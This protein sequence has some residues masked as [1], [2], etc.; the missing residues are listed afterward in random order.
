MNVLVGEKAHFASGTH[1]GDVF[2]M[3][4]FTSEVQTSKQVFP[5]DALVALEQILKG[6]AIG[7]PVEHELHRDPC[8]LDHGLPHQHTGPPLNPISPTHREPSLRQLRQAYSE[9]MA[10]EP[11]ADLQLGCQF[12]ERL[13]PAASGAFGHLRV[14]PAGVLEGHL[15][16]AVADIFQ[17]D[18]DDRFIVYVCR[19]RRD[20]PLQ[21]HDLLEHPV[22]RI[23]QP[24]GERITRE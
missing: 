3:D 19:H 21:R 6:P 5:G 24:S 13:R 7:Q 18:R 11:L 17:F 23:S 15:G 10:P 16:S 9:L 20:E 2:F 14:R 22:L 1:T 8:A 4:N 12:L